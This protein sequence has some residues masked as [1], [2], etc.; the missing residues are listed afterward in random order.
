MAEINY[1]KKRVGR[2]GLTVW[3]WPNLT[4]GDIAVPAFMETEADKAFHIFGAASGATTV[5]K[6]SNDVTIDAT[7]N[8]LELN[9]TGTGVGLTDVSGAS[10]SVT[11][12]TA[13]GVIAPHTVYLWPEVSGGDGDTD[14]TIAIL[15]VE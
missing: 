2:N 13:L 12:D 15:G 1:T 3:T 7:S 4:S 14:V 6:G 8:A 11:S 10:I 9:S 5:L